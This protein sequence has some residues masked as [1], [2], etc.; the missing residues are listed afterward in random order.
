D[1]AT[2]S[3]T[4]K[5]Q[6][7]GV[8]LLVPRLSVYNEANELVGTATATDPEHGDVLVQLDDAQPGATY[9]FKVEGASADVFGIGGY[10]LKI[11]LGDAASALQ[12][13][14][15]DSV[16]SGAAGRQVSQDTHA[17]NTLA[18]ATNLAYGADSRFDYSVTGS[19]SHATEVDYYQLVAPGPAG[20]APQALIASIAALNGSGLYANISVYDQNGQPVAADTLVNDHGTM[21]VQVP[22]ATPG[23]TYYVAVSPAGNA[24]H[25]AGDYM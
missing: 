17:N 5:V 15:L 8:S 16:Y 20:V 9:Y 21:V 24:D 11:D 13:E 19:F 7:S 23:G 10:R 6:T 18:T 14:V 3:L 12:I 22:N 1:Y 4:V 2:G 25:N